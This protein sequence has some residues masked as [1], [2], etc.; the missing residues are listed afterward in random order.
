VKE[1]IDAGRELVRR[2]DRIRPVKA[3]FWLKASAGLHWY[4]YLASERTDAHKDDLSYQEVTPV[5]REMDNPD[6][7]GFRI[8]V[9]AADD[10]LALAAVEIAER[11]PMAAGRRLGGG[12]FGGLFAD[13]MYIYPLPLPP[14]TGPRSDIRNGTAKVPKSPLHYKIAFHRDEE[15]ISVSVPALP[16]CWSE[17]NTEEEALSNIRDAI[18]EYLAGL[19]DRFRDAEVREVEVQA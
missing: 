9:I 16:G 3:A 10:P 2:L 19:E 11:Y 7:D 13:D 1:E 17:G 12:P 4:L 6:L 18:C 5:E 8:K 14:W 15:G